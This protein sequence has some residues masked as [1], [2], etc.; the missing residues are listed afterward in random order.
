MGSGGMKALDCDRILERI[1]QAGAEV[2]A[3]GRGGV[4]FP[5]IRKALLAA[6]G[7][8]PADTRLPSIRQ[9]AAALNTT[10]IPTQRAVTELK[11]EGIIY[12]KPKAGIFMRGMGETVSRRAGVDMD[13]GSMPGSGLRVRF[14]S[15]CGHPDNR[16]LWDEIVRMFRDASECSGVELDFRALDGS[17]P[18]A[19][20]PDMLEGFDWNFQRDFKGFKYLRLKDFLPDAFAHGGFAGEALAPIYHHAV[21]LLHNVTALRRQGLPEPAYRDFHEQLDYCRELRAACGNGSSVQPIQLG[22]RLA[23]D[24]TAAFRDGVDIESSGIPERFQSLVDFATNF[25]Y[26]ICG[27]GM[28]RRFE[29]GR[30]L[31][32]LAGSEVARQY[33]NHPLPF[34]WRA[35]PAFGL[36]GGLVKVPVVAAALEQT[37][38]PVECARWIKHLLSPPVQE[39]FAAFGYFT[40]DMDDFSRVGQSEA[41]GRLMAERFRA[42]APSFAGSFAE[43]YV[44]AH[45]VNDEIWNCIKGSQSAG[46]AFRNVVTYSRAYLRGS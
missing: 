15:G 31:L 30:S 5:L 4:K 34:E 7:K 41:G 18:A 17:A 26:R 23:A 2:V 21:F 16:I 1:R 10:V 39:R 20:L 8:L 27:E 45:I 12:I 46:A 33:W 43:Y 42:S 22:G 24:L 32:Y 25:A 28:E 13:S 6:C 3:G 44:G 40:E 14:L 19:P 36:D 35:Y 37:Q 9:I 38:S 11:D 29:S